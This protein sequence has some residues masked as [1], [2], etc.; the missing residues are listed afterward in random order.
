MIV[1]FNKSFLFFVIGSF[2]FTKSM[3]YCL[4]P[5]ERG[6]FRFF[7]F[8]MKISLSLSFCFPRSSSIRALRI[9]LS[10]T[11]RSSSP[12]VK[13]S[14]SLGKSKKVGTLKHPTLNIFRMRST[15]GQRSRTCQSQ[16]QISTW[17]FRRRGWTLLAPW[18]R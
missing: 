3:H 6:Q 8:C 14:K 9:S 4:S 12:L 1:L 17:R 13:P 7:R 10:R 15:M 11:R 18:L 5:I 16:P 2:L